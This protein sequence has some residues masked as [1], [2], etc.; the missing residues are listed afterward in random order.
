[1]LNHSLRRFFDNRLNDNLVRLR[2]NHRLRFLDLLNLFGHL[3]HV[4]S[5]GV[6][7]FFAVRVL[8]RFYNRGGFNRRFGL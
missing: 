6:D 4:F 2:N 3:N 1:M 5:E 8:F 7:L